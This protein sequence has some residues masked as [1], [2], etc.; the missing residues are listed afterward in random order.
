M[1][2]SYCAGSAGRLVSVLVFAGLWVRSSLRSDLASP[3]R[4]GSLAP[5]TG[6][7][8]HIL[9]ADSAGREA[10]GDSPDVELHAASTSTLA[11]ALLPEEA[12]PPS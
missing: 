9:S 11:G 6:Q 8:A 12:G 4:T 3:R 7:R 2:H 1:K 10:P 5:L